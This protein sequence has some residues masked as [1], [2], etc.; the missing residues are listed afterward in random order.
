MIPQMAAT[1]SDAAFCEVTVGPCGRF[2]FAQSKCYMYRPTF[3][4]FA[5]PRVT[6]HCSLRLVQLPSPKTSASRIQ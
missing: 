3:W 5:A 2:V 4:S 6:L 1:I